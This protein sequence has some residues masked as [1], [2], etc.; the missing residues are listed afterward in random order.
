MNSSSSYS[1]LNLR[2]FSYSFNALCN[3]L[4]SPVLPTYVNGSFN[5]WR[6]SY[7][8]FY[9]FS[10]IF[11]V[12]SISFS[13]SFFNS[14][15]SYDLIWRYTAAFTLLGKWS[16]SIFFS[17]L[18]SSSSCVFFY[19]ISVDFLFKKFFYLSSITVAR[20]FAEAAYLRAA[21]LS[22]NS[23]SWVWH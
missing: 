16:T 18:S 12:V 10:L 13:S 19:G 4:S 5:F 7:F 14:S 17:V 23:P 6:A 9:I 21:I 1:L 8:Y 2:F 20:P 3:S 15:K 11:L 22:L